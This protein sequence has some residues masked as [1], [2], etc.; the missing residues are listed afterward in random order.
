MAEAEAIGRKG[1]RGSVEGIQGE[2]SGGKGTPV[3]VKLH[4]MEIVGDL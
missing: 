3:P 1:G 4:R 2:R